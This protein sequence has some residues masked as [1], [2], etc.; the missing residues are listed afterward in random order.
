MADDQQGQLR[1]LLQ[2]PDDFLERL[3]RSGLDLGLVGIEVDAV[4]GGM[5]WSWRSP[6]QMSA[7]A[8]ISLHIRLLD[9]VQLV[10]LPAVTAPP[11]LIQISLSVPRTSLRWFDHPRNPRTGTPRRRRPGVAFTVVRADLQRRRDSAFEVG[12]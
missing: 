5:T 9:D 10:V 8:T 11:T 1:V 12:S 7:L 6:F 4:D 2:Q 3:L